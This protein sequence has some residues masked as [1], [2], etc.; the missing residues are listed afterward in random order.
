MKLCPKCGKHFSDDAN[1]CPVDAARLAPLDGAGAA[2]E[3][4]ALGARFDL[5]ERL[6]GATTGEVRKATDKQSGQ[7]A[8]VKL[9]APAVMGLPQVAQRIER[10]LKQLER[11][12][13]ASV[14][15]VL[16]SGKRGDAAWVATQRRPVAQG[17]PGAGS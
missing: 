9:I 15:R 2:E 6:G 8:V 12:E 1:F 11:V 13:T 10:E 14:A 4:D 7:P 17:S 3:T 5:G 16:G